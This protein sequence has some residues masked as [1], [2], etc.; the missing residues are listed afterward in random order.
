MHL[1]TFAVNP[2]PGPK[3]Q[4]FTPDGNQNQQTETCVA[5]ISTRERRGRLILGI[6]QFVIAMAILA[7][8]T[9]L[10]ADHVWRLPLF[11]LFAGAATSFFQWRDKTCVALARHGTRK[12]TDK[13]EKIE[14]QAELA[15]VRRQARKVLIKGC[16]TAAVL[17]LIVLLLP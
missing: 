16:L 3:T 10:G 14:D 6:I 11:L 5:N 9:G 17:T 13:M 1:T 12:L 4:L 15:Q 2:I 7:G 8:L